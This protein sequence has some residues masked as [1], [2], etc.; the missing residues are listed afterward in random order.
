MAMAEFRDS[1][2][3]AASP[4]TVFDY[5]TTD[6]GMTAWM[7]QYADLDPTPGGRFAVD[8]AGYPVRGTFLT[9]ERPSRVVVSW[10]FAGSDDLPA[11]TSTVEFRLTPIAGGTRVDLCHSHLPDTR[12]PGHALGWANFLPRLVIASGGGDPGPDHWQPS[13]PA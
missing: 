3:I 9:V 13:S 1:I 11:G 7:G 12:V 2:D 4:E 10:G 8:I 6:D 5:L